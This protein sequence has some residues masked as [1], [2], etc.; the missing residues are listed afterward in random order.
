MCTLWAD[1]SCGKDCGCGDSCTCG[2]VSF[3]YLAEV[4]AS[5][6][7]YGNCP[8]STMCGCGKDCKCGGS[9]ERTEAEWIELAKKSLEAKSGE[10]PWTDCSC[11]EA[12]GEC[13]CM[14]SCGCGSKK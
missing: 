1:C 13:K 7:M 12:G 9:T 14:A 5:S 11:K 4:K 3:D 10:C 8:C 6:C 2:T